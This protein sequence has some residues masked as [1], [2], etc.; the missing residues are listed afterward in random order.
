MKAY[1][2]IGSRSTPPR[3]WPAIQDV[4]IK[5]AKC[6]Y[7]LRSGAADGADAI[8]E[9]A[10]LSV[11]GSVE[12]FLPWPCFNGHGSKRSIPHPDAFEIAANA[13]PAWHRCSDAARKLHARNVHQ[14]LGQDLITPSK[15]VVCWTPGGAVVGGTATAIRV[16]QRHGIAVHNLAIEDP[17]ESWWL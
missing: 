10:A 11:A 8:F 9:R 5:L 16:A 3:I 4:A 14:V 2:G 6:D 17:D 15:F 12:I 1:A 13:H 7:I